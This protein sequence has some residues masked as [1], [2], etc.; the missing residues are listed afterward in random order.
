MPKYKRL[1]E[2]MNENDD[3]NLNEYAQEVSQHNISYIIKT[4]KEISP[5]LSEF[6]NNVIM[7]KSPFNIKSEKEA[8]ELLYDILSYKYHII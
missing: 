3:Q 5:E 6:L 8:A 4:A 1:N 2:F 7:N